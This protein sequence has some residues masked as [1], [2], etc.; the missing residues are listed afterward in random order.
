MPTSSA[1]FVTSSPGSAASTCCSEGWPSTLASLQPIDFCTEL[2]SPT[3][4]WW[5]IKS[6]LSPCSSISVPH[7]GEAT[8][9]VLA[10]HRGIRSHPGGLFDFGHGYCLINL[11]GPSSSS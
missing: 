3:P 1:P 10:Q 2:K 7:N 11:Q 5:A 4:Y 6:S 9:G 8:S